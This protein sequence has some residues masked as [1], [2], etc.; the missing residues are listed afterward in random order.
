MKSVKCF[1]LCLFRCSNSSSFSGFSLFYYDKILL[2]HFLLLNKLWTGACCIVFHTVL[3][4]ICSNFGLSVTIH[5]YYVPWC[6]VYY[7]PFVYFFLSR[8]F[9]LII[10]KHSF[11]L[12]LSGR[13][14][15]KLA[16]FLSAWV[17]EV[18]CGS[19]RNINSIYRWK[20][21]CVV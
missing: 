18:I 21:M 10:V 3:D 13:V 19:F 14:C 12:I 2:L 15:V 4:L 16:S 9:Y 11:L 1:L 6:E 8:W 7:S 17:L 5:H 20:V